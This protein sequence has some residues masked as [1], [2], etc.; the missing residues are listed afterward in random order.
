MGFADASVCPSCRGRIEHATRCPHCGLDL[1]IHEVQQAWQVPF[2]A[3]AL[4]LA[5]LTLA[6]LGPVALA[7][8]RWTLLAVAGVVLGGAGITWEDRVRDGRAAV[9]NVGSMR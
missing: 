4:V 8:P 1:T 6:N 5:A 2:V 9:R 7:V 3:G